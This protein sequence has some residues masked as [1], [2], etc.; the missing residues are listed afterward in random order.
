MARFEEAAAAGLLTTTTFPRR[1]LVGPAL[2]KPR[3]PAY[4][5]TA[6]RPSWSSDRRGARHHPVPCAD[7]PSPCRCS[8]PSSTTRLSR[9]GGSDRDAA[10]RRPAPPPADSVRD[11]RPDDRCRP[12]ASPP[13][14][15]SADI[16]GRFEPPSSAALGSVE[17]QAARCRLVENGHGTAVTSDEPTRTPIQVPN[18]SS[19]A[20]PANSSPAASY[21]VHGRTAS[22]TSTR[23]RPRAVSPS[24]RPAPCKYDLEMPTDTA[25]LGQR[26]DGKAGGDPSTPCAKSPSSLT[27]WST[28]RPS[29]PKRRL[30]PRTSIRRHAMFAL[31][32]RRPQ[33]SAT[34][35][36]PRCPVFG[37]QL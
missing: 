8:Y 26:P 18:I 13:R 10:V 15:W 32:R 36:S 20:C 16:L 14:R 19:A 24:P 37:A 21:S 2:E 23:D 29:R 31:P 25:V 35:P 17:Q 12:A 27:S 22:A 5:T 3:R 1:H 11:H 28:E 6:E 34:P 9:V 33:A 4:R 30:P 7:T